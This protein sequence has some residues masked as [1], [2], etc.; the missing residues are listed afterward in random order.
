MLL[1][2]GHYSKFVTYSLHAKFI[3][4]KTAMLVIKLN[5]QDW[6]Q[7]EIFFFFFISHMGINLEGINLEGINKDKQNDSIDC[8]DL[9]A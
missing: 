6:K 5:V 4:I 8:I 9:N 1:C 7:G 2:N 3:E